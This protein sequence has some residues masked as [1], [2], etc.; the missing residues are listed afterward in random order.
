MINGDAWEAGQD[1]DNL[2]VQNTGAASVITKGQSIN[3]FQSIKHTVM[4]LIAA[5]GK[6]SEVKI[7]Q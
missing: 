2:G 5:N 4:L 7:Q 3:A 6:N 1:P